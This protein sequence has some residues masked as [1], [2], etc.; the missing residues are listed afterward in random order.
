MSAAHCIYIDHKYYKDFMGEE[1]DNVDYSSYPVKLVGLKIGWIL[2]DEAGK[3][4]LQSIAASEDM[5]LYETPTLQ[6][7]VE[8]IY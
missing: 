7:I 1:K 6:M 4:F 5:S 3:F 2:N 8:F